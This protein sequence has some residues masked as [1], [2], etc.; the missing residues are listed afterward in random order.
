MVCHRLKQ[1]QFDIYKIKAPG[2]T[3]LYKYSMYKYTFT[4]FGIYIIL[5]IFPPYINFFQEVI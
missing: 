3:I 1:L 2:A 5:C 4:A